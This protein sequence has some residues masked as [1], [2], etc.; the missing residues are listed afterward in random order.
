MWPPAAVSGAAAERRV[1]VRV[2]VRVRRRLP[3]AA[4]RAE[5]WNSAGRARDISARVV[6]VALCAPRS[7]TRAALQT[8]LADFSAMRASSVEFNDFVKDPTISRPRKAAALDAVLDTKGYSQITRDFMG[9]PLLPRCVCACALCAVRRQRPVV[10]SGLL[11]VLVAF[12]RAPSCSALPSIS[13]CIARPG[14]F[15]LSNV[16]LPFN[17]RAATWHQA[18]SRATA[19]C[20]TCTR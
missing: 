4:A 19:A 5:I 7:Q 10:C 2:R 6:P 13:K 14:P 8:D 11:Y 20:R 3:A 17:E 12:V 18:W 9:A 15:S 1:R 16:V